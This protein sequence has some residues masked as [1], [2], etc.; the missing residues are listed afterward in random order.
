M[1]YCKFCATCGA[2]LDEETQA[3]KYYFNEGYE[4]EVILCFLLKYHEIQMSLRTLKSLGL[5][6]RKL[7]S[8]LCP[9]LGQNMLLRPKKMAGVRQL[10][11]MHFQIARFSPLRLYSDIQSEYRSKLSEFGFGVTFKNSECAFAIR[12]DR[13]YEFGVSL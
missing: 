3:L 12:S 9:Q 1:L 11:K 2:K 13:F 10:P 7:S 4:Y 5:R 6:R 8:H